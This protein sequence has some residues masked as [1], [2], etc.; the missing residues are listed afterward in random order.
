M[1]ASEYARAVISLYS[2]MSSLACTGADDQLWKVEGSRIVHAS[3]GKCL[4]ADPNNG[5]SVQVY[6][7]TGATNQK[8]TVSSS[9]G[10]IKNQ[11]TAKCLDV[12]GLN[13]ADGTCRCWASIPAPA[14]R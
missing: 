3:S 7:C 1:C 2:T 6:A 9:A 11:Q 13:T 12:Y 10:T 4:D 8:W 14:R 5:D